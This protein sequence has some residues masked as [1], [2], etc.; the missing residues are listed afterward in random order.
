[1]T[2]VLASIYFEFQAV[3]A[4]NHPNFFIRHMMETAIVQLLL[5]AY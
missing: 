3:F 4:R 5:L 2:L 1:M